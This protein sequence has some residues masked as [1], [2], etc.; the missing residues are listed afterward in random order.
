MKITVLGC[1]A[2]GQLWLIFLKK[3]GYSV[4][5]W[6]KEQHDH[7]KIELVDIDG[8]II[9]ECFPANNNLHLA[10]SELLIVTLKAWQVAP[11]L[12]KLANQL[13]LNCPILLLHNGIGT[14]EELSHF[15]QPKIV[16]ITTHAAYRNKNRVYHT[17]QGTT[18][19]CSENRTHS[20]NY[21]TSILNSVLPTVINCENIKQAQWI[22]LAINCVINPLTVIYNCCNGELIK[23]LI[24]IQTLCKEL[25]LVM[26]AEKINCSFDQL[27]HETLSVI[28]STKNN[29]SSML[30]DI[31]AHR[32]TEIDY[33]TG[34]LMQRARLHHINIPANSYLYQ[35]IK[36][37]ESR[38]IS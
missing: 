12:N 21:L 4:Q 17:A 18:L 34:Y 29:I 10:N 6:L 22:K 36:E 26:Q 3:Q 37:K 8:V 32:R 30:Q 16:A 5:G 7:L 35:L 24:V 19:I 38:F 20:L 25:I 13:P 23:Y 28:H 1:G 14:L 2:I 31:R 15:T 27:I 9:K 11:A 33:I